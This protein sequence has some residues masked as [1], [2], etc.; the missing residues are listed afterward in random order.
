MKKKLQPIKLGVMGFGN[1]ADNIVSGLINSKIV[2]PRHV[3]AYELNQDRARFISNK[4]QIK[5]CTHAK[6]LL[7]HGQ[8]ILICVKPQNIKEA[9]TALQNKDS[10]QL[11]I[12]IV[13]A[14][15]VKTYHSFFGSKTRII[16]VMPNTPLC[17]GY[18]ATVYYAEKN[19]TQNDKKLCELF[20]GSMGIIAQVTKESLMNA[21]TAV[22]GSGPAFLYQ[23]ALAMMNS[24]VKQGI[25]KKTAETLVLQTL[26]GATQMMRH[27][28]KT[29][30]ELTALVAT[31]GGTTLA[32]LDAL[33][34]KGFTRA[35]D[36]CIEKATQR[37]FELCRLL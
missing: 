18:G 24:A 21:V 4:Y 5:F 2:N 12:T 3:L 36:A 30:D 6:E 1:M 34:K 26:L 27:S 32:G 13:T 15:P 9:L 29:P 28:D 22:S 7:Q 33:Y 10:K 11:L 20:F 16:R 25:P 31:K 14:V 17:I 37:A 35:I 8:V 23:Y 19:C